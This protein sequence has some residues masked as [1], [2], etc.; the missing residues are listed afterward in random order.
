M[1]WDRYG[2]TWNPGAG[3]TWQLLGRRNVNAPAL[4]VCD[5]RLAKGVYILYDDYG[6]TYAGIAR[7]TGGLGA[8]LRTHHSKP[9]R[10]RDWTRFSWFTF[11][12]VHDDPNH[13]CW[14]T[15]RL[16]RKPVPTDDDTIIREME[17]LLIKV[18]GT[19]QNKM[20]FQHAHEWEQL[21]PHEAAEIRDKGQADPAL[22]LSKLS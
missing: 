7:G 15:V 9:P 3:D 13:V 6:P 19:Q 17:A 20:K 22:F 14:E 12:D 16:R 2:V 21:W 5:F 4:R 10:R 1:F 18:L 11:D 8:R